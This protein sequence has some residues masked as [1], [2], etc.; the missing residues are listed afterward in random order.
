MDTMLTMYTD[1]TVPL[2]NIKVEFICEE[3]DDFGGLTD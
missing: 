3:C 1:P 2:S